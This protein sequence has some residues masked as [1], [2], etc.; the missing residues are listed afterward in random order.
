MWKVK[1]E[2]CSRVWLAVCSIEQLMCMSIG[3]NKLVE[4]QYKNVV[5]HNPVERWANNSSADTLLMFV[6]SQVYA[7]LLA[8]ILDNVEG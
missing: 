2:A 5:V 4:L 6:G 1:A 8:F 7:Q 3:H